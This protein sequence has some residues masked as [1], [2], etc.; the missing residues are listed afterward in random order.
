M[1]R[2]RVALI[3]YGAI[4]RVH[5]LG[6]KAIPYHYG[7]PN[8]VVRVVAVASIAKETVPPAVAAWRDA[9]EGWTLATV[10]GRPGQRYVLQHLT[11]ESE[12]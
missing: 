5:A 8:D 12:R 9:G 4:G 1:K 7:L 11:A 10:H 3:G 6:Y 2:L